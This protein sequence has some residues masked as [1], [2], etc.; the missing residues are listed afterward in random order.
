MQNSVIKLNK[1]GPWVRSDQENANLFAKYLMSV[2][3]S[4]GNNA[5]LTIINETN[6][7]L[8]ALNATKTDNT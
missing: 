8:D 4:K 1:S 5:D 3:M 6:S 2:F 7:T